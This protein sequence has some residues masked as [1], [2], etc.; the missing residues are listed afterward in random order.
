MK[1][2]ILLLLSLSIA[3]AKLNV[4]TTT[5]DLASITREI[6]G[7]LI[8]VDAI[9][10]GTQD[11]HFIEAKPSY[12]VKASRADLAV[13]IG[14]DLET[15]W[16]QSVLRGARNPNIMQGSKGFLEIGP[17]VDPLDVP[18]GKI[19]RAEGDVHP[20]GN[21]HFTLDP[22]RMG[23]AAKVIA[24]KLAELDSQN[25]A[26]YLSKAETISKRLEEK[27]KIWRARITKSGIKNAISY[28][29]TLNYFFDRFG[30]ENSA[31]LEPKP[32]IPPTSGHILEVIQIIQNKKIPLILVENFFDA[33]VTNKI[34]ETVPGIRVATVPVAV[35]GETYIKSIDDLYEYLVKT[36]E[37]K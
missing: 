25:S 20:F 9:C 28:H 4:I 1:Y 11:P 36:V 18:G 22:I 17:S 29:K 35:D 26:I 7:D 6:G 32:G 27:T 8:S 13:S 5:T 12:M 10:K 16:L 24:Q 23:K 37:G 34:K 21:P 3:E 30:I 31:I 19:T 14:L 33:S 15:A 2:L